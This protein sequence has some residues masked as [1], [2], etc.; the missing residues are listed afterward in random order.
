MR[1]HY[2]GLQQIGEFLEN[3]I[4][5]LLEIIFSK[6]WRSLCQDLILQFSST[7]LTGSQSFPVVST[8]RGIRGPEICGSIFVSL[9]AGRE[10]VWEP[11]KLGLISV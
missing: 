2:K 10:N 5:A 8:P 9:L 3:L 1:R 6:E 7:P 4:P 11:L